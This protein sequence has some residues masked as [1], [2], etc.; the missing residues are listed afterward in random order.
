MQSFEWLCNDMLL[1]LRLLQKGGTTR[2]WGDLHCTE[3][4]LECE[5]V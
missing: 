1:F 2:R 5:R 3:Q 4:F